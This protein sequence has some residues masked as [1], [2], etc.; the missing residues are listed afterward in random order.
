M[1]LTFQI[2]Q[3]GYQ[4]LLPEGSTSRRFTVLIRKKSTRLAYYQA[5]G[6]FNYLLPPSARIF[7]RA[8]HD[9]ARVRS[10]MGPRLKM[11]SRIAQ[12]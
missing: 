2:T 8:A 10:P 6:Q 1:L 5:I 9:F 11:S 4:R 12:N 7:P 3:I